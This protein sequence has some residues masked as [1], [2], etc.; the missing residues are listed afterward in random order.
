MGMNSN[1]PIA[2]PT[3]HATNTERMKLGTSISMSGPIASASACCRSTDCPHSQSFELAHS[4]SDHFFEL[5]DCG[6]IEP[7]ATLS[8]GICYWRR[9]PWCS[10]WKED[11]P[12]AKKYEDCF[13]HRQAEEHSVH[14]CTSGRPQFH[15]FME[16]APEL[17]ERIYRFIL[18]S[19]GPINPHLCDTKLE[20]HDDSQPR[21]HGAI[22]ALLR[23][24]RVSKQVREESLPVFY[25]VNTFTI[26]KDTA[27]YFD[28]LE[29]LG[30]F[31]MIRHVR[32]DIDMRKESSTALTLRSMNQFIKEAEAYEDSLT[33]KDQT[34]KEPVIFPGTEHHLHAQSIVTKR[35]AAAIVGESFASLT[36]HPQYLAGGVSELSA[37][38]VLRK[39]KTTF[40]SS[41]GV[42][43]TK[44]VLPVP[45]AD[46]FTQYD[47]LKWFPTVCY[48]LGIDL[49]F[50]EN[51]PFDCAGQGFFTLTWHQKYQKKDFASKALGD[52]SN[53]MVRHVDVQSRLLELFPDLES[54]PRPR[55]NTYYRY[56][57]D[58]ELRAWYSVPTE[59]GGIRG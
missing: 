46:I 10:N 51:I 44:L 5:Q 57:C 31:H 33:L 24:T 55:V 26:G 52:A 58:G 36:D 27:T 48:G 19:D 8:Q 35:S 56:G 38:I 12:N 30:R 29:H 25:S 15:Q 11:G 47:S 6:G 21:R 32:F 2:G 53:D 49:H 45:R 3:T 20:F 50:V 37:L 34:I 43:T 13:K 9:P 42:Q 59:G 40:S 17:R 1:N 16:L 4:N 7:D 14:D 39:L 22:G 41:S 18:A 54:M 28:R 23:I